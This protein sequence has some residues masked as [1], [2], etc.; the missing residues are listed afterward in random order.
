MGLTDIVNAQLTH[1]ASTDFTNVIP[2]NGVGQQVN[3]FDAII[4]YLGGLLSAYDLLTSDFVPEGT[5][6]A[7]LIS[8]LL[9][10]AVVVGEHLKPQFN[11]PSGLPASFV[12]FATGMINNTMYKDPLNNVTYPDNN[13]AVCG[14]IILEFYR[15]SDVTGDQSYRQLADRAEAYFV[16]PNPAPAYPYL[17]GS[18][19]DVE[20]GNFI[21]F[22]FGCKAT[23]DSFLEYLVKSYI[24]NPRKSLVSS[25]YLPFWLGAV[26]SSLT[27]IVESPVGYPQLTYLTQADASG[28]KEHAMDDYACFAGG[29][30]LYGSTYL[31]KEGSSADNLAAYAKLGLDVTSSCHYLYT[32]TATGLGPE[33][34]GWFDQPGKNTFN[35][36]WTNNVTYQNSVKQRGYF[37]LNPEYDSFPESIESIWYAYRITGNQMYQD[38]NW[39]IFNSIK[40]ESDSAARVQYSSIM[41]V[42]IPK[43]FMGDLPSFYFAE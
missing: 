30:I 6:D 29:N 40:A 8:A 7:R 17:I 9:K 15:L 5:Y 33:Q 21:T 42:Y 31:Q 27:N 10:Q 34:W 26:Q 14:T 3:G 12:D 25:Q 1:I 2:P 37:I 41:N 43:S 39:A 16:H 23:I 4:R 38:W 35:Q 32:T 28:A 18:E 19:L 36:T 20:T 11:T 24:Y 22:D 13:A